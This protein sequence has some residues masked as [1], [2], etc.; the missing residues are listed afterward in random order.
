M[1]DVLRFE[2]DD[3][4]VGRLTLTRPD[5]RNALDGELIA[6]VTETVSRLPASCRVLVIAGEG[7]VFSAGADLNW[8]RSMKGFT[9][10]ENVEDSRALHDMFEALDAC[11]VPVVGRIHGA[12]IAGAAGLV[13]CCDVAVAAEGTLFAFT[14]VRLGLVP[15]VIS[16]WVIRKVG[17]SFARATMLTAERFDARRAYEAGLVHRIVPDDA[18]DAVV[19]EDVDGLLAAGPQ[20]LARTRR[21][22]DEVWGRQPAETGD[23]TAEVIA[24]ARVSEEGQEGVAAFFDKRKPRWAPG[25]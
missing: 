9:H 10:E 5:V 7:R 12:A 22:L 2:V 4:G 21:L 24:A 8:M 13:A 20:A 18:L 19:G 6:R 17:Y 11:P 16:P 14:E 3:R 1:S 23:L 15:A 25:D